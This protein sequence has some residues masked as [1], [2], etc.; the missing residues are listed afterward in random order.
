MHFRVQPAEG[1]GD[2][3]EQVGE[4]VHA[5]VAVHFHLALF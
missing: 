3:L 4:D 2:G 5:L 1:A